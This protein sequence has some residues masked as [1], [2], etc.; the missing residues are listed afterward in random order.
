M[1]IPAQSAESEDPRD[2]ASPKPEEPEGPPKL[3]WLLGVALVILSVGFVVVGAVEYAK[4]TPRLVDLVSLQW[5][6]S[7]KAALQVVMA[8]SKDL[9]T[10]V[11]DFQTAVRWDFALIAAYTIGLVLACYL[12]LRV[13]CTTA[14]SRWSIY[15]LVAAVVAGAFNAGQDVLLRAG[16]SHLHNDWIFRFAATASFL[17]FT[18]LLVAVPIAAASVCT[19]TTRLVTHHATKKRWS[20]AADLASQQWK[21]GANN[22][23]VVPPPPVEWRRE[24]PGWRPYDLDQSINREWWTRGHHGEDGRK[25]HFAQD[26]SLPGRQSD[27]KDGI[28][29]S[30]GGIRSATVTLGA[31]QGLRPHVPLKEVEH[32][33]SV[34][35]GGY[36]AGGFQL[37]LKPPPDAS[38]SNNGRHPSN[39]D[40]STVFAPGS[41][42]ED[43][44]RRHSSYL[45]D[46]AGQWAV[47]LGVILRNLLASLAIIGLT[48]TTLGIAIGQFYRHVPIIEGS[49]TKL[50]TAT[51]G[52]N[53]PPYPAPTWPVTLGLAVLAGLAVVGYVIRLGWT[54]F[55]GGRSKW[56]GRIASVVTHVANA[57]ACATVLLL[58]VGIVVPTLVWLSS[59]V[60]YQLPA[61]SRPGVAAGSLSVIVSFVGALAATLWRNK[62]KVKSA[63]DSGTKVVKG[64]LPNSMIQMLI[65]WIALI[66]LGLCAVLAAGWVA[67]SGLPESLWAMAVVIPLIVVSLVVDQTSMSLHPFYR[68]RLAS[69]FAVRR[70]RSD[71]VVVAKPYDYDRE[72]TTLSVYAAK[73][74]GFPSVTFAA[75]ANLTGQDRTPPGRR[76][77]SFTFGSEYVG[78]PQVG[79]VRTKYLE[80]LAKPAI[81]HDLTVQSAVAISGAAFASAMGS[82]TRFYELFL[83]LANLRLGAWLP[84][85]YFVALKAK[86]LTDWTVPGLPRLRRLDYFAREIFGIHPSSGR[87]VLCTD[88]GHYDN[89]GLVE[90][91][92]RR[93]AVIY[94]FDASGASRPLA[95]T[96]AGAMTLAHEELGIEIEL[97][98]EYELVAGGG[99]PLDPEKPLAALTDQLSKS[100]VITASIQYP[101]ANGIPAFVGKMIFA[102]AD[103]TRDM[104][105]DV[106]EFT[107]TDPGFPNDG[108]A[109]QWFDV[110]RFDAYQRLGF[111]LGEQVAAALGDL[112]DV[113]PGTVSG[114]GQGPGPGGRPEI[115]ERYQEVEHRPSQRPSE[116]ASLTEP[117]NPADGGVPKTSGLGSAG[118]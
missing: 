64:V 40:P 91:L 36:T 101:D 43:H 24:R 60:T 61:T 8:D 38:D 96:L 14:P 57:L 99:T 87:M 33:V 105:Y 100:A 2:V 44:L 84:N 56:A 20:R 79:W 93:C 102:Q 51:A 30:G 28:C 89:L 29:V 69:A 4:R 5:S 12:G 118:C 95:D 39:A 66:V 18:A 9:Q 77:A 13:F 103:L 112:T 75:S 72:G 23:L 1:N 6:G 74:D 50:H 81:R 78:G 35:G 94:C 3:N 42:E 110:S 116:T 16:L 92:R 32:L 22:P 76:S 114:G 68:R 117:A 113:P 47:A 37:A 98:D 58:G 62:Q 86:H 63:L 90:L 80:E 85:P 25:V 17:K 52:T 73:H 45:S 21:P 54:A 7:A 70:T 15:G 41:P 27:G 82:Q 109:D 49:L 26:F 67:T 106:L 65:I 88:G 10:A 31:I 71:G 11:N 46:G 59:W 34:S 104:P 97:D 115:D 107:Q 48:V 108:T 111:Y 19:A 53:P 83:S 55:A